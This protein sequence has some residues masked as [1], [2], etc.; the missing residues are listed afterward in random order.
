MPVVLTTAEAEPLKPRV[1]FRE[2]LAPTRSLAVAWLEDQ[3]AERVSRPPREE[4]STV[5][6]VVSSAPILLIAGTASLG[7]DGGDDP[8]TNVPDRRSPDF[9]LGG[10]IR[11]QAPSKAIWNECGVASVRTDVAVHECDLPIA[12]SLFGSGTA[13][14]RAKYCIRKPRQGCV[15]VESAYETDERTSTAILRSDAPCQVPIGIFP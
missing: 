8:T 12:L 14:P 2:S 10:D 6:R 5:R 13:R 1:A 7:T 3:S 9:G 4:G 11:A 15:G